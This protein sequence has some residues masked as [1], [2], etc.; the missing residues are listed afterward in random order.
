MTVNEDGTVSIVC[1]SN[2]CYTG[3]ITI[4]IPSNAK[5]VEVDIDAYRDGENVGGGQINLQYTSGESDTTYNWGK[6]VYWD[7]SFD[8]N[9][10]KGTP[11]KIVMN[12]Q[13]LG[14]TFVIKSIR[15]W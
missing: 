4:N 12:N 1:T 14:T 6:D 2:G 8:V 10:E 15:V 9:S 11:T 7:T 5:K 13:D 3:G